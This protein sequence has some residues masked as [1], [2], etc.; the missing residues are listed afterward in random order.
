MSHKLQDEFSWQLPNMIVPVCLC[1]DMNFCRCLPEKTGQVHSTG[2][3][4]CLALLSS[5][6]LFTVKTLSASF[7]TQWIIQQS[8]IIPPVLFCLLEYHPVVQ[9]P[10][11]FRHKACGKCRI[12]KGWRETFLWCWSPTNSQCLDF[13]LERESQ[14]PWDTQHKSICT[15]CVLCKVE[16][17]SSLT[18]LLG[19]ENKIHWNLGRSSK[20]QIRIFCSTYTLRVRPVNFIS[21]CKQNKDWSVPQSFPM[22]CSHRYYTV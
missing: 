7:R 8:F 20:E 21:K 4:L 11:D 15:S 9:H 12:P 14:L 16:K 5:S 3:G 17:F 1:K 18:G 19:T 13:L 6:E 2:T 10:S 22:P